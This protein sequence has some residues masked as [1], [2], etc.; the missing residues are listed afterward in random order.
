MP[1]TQWILA[2][3]YLGV[4]T[5]LE[6]STYLAAAREALEEAQEGLEAT[7]L[8]IAAMPV[9]LSGGRVLMMEGDYQQAAAEFERCVGISYPDEEARHELFL[10]LARSH[11]KLKE[12]DQAESWVQR[13]LDVAPLAPRALAEAARIAWAR[14]NHAEAR[15]TMHRALDVWQVADPGFVYAERARETLAG[16]DRVS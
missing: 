14:G 15:E 12:L 10:G 6:D 1:G 4:Y 5:T 13:I 3:G 7:G 11:R 16:W 2:L 9:I 8:G